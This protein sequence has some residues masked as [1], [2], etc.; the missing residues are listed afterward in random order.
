[1]TH[2]IFASYVM[3]GFKKIQYTRY[4]ICLIFYNNSLLYSPF[5]LVVG[6]QS[7]HSS[8]RGGVPFNSW[9]SIY[10]SCPGGCRHSCVHG[11]PT[12]SPL[13]LLQC[14]H[15]ATLLP[16]GGSLAASN[17]FS[18]SNCTPSNTA[19]SSKW[20]CHLPGSTIWPR[21]PSAV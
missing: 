6:K 7:H 13:L 12:S 1:M 10:S 14:P 21:G 18:S 5:F 9:S 8:L 3:L 11:L 20:S 2:L 17:A 15:S 4:S 19:I 16:K